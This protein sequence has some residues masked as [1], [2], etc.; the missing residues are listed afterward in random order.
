MDNGAF[1]VTHKKLL[2]RV[3]VFPTRTK[4]PL[5]ITVTKRE[6]VSYHRN[7]DEGG[8]L[9]RVQ[10]EVPLEFVH[11]LARQAVVQY[12]NDHPATS[13]QFSNSPDRGQFLPEIPLQHKGN[14]FSALQYVPESDSK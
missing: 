5:K 12:K 4:D 10:M 14:K 1:K 2:D 9:Q 13:T 7:H 6:L 3:E 8:E 11:K